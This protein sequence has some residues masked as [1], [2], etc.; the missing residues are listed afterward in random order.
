VRDVTI[1]LELLELNPRWR[2]VNRILV[3]LDK[4]LTK[5][6]INKEPAIIVMI[7]RYRQLIIMAAMCKNVYLI[8]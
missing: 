3:S 4:L 8:K 1:I 5:I 2:I 6:M 7:T